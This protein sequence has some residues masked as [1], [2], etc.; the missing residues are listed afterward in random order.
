LAL[1]GSHSL[2]SAA[3]R[4]T[5]RRLAEPRPARRGKRTTGGVRGAQPHNGRRLHEQVPGHCLWAVRS[6]KPG[7]ERGP[8]VG[9]ELSGIRR[10]PS[11]RLTRGCRRQ[12]RLTRPS[13]GRARRSHRHHHELHKNKE[14]AAKL[15][16]PRL[17]IDRGWEGGRQRHRKE[18]PH[19]VPA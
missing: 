7:A 14:G 5:D 1:L 13:T 8:R 3:Q 10:A 16:I 12:P 11:Q 2:A 6:E 18:V 17:R 15:E 9:G 19:M 4:R